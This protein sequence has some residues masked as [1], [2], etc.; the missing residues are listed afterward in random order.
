M[1]TGV[2]KVGAEHEVCMSA[3]VVRSLLYCNKQWC[4][5]IGRGMLRW[6]GAA[7]LGMKCVC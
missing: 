2:T 7:Q 1:D 6:G 5:H 3:E 4:T